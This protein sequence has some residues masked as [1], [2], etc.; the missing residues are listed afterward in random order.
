MSDLSEDE[1]ESTKDSKLAE[2]PTTNKFLKKKKPSAAAQAVES[3]KKA[4]ISDTSAS[5]SKAAPRMG[6]SGASAALSKAAAFTSKYGKPAKKEKV[7]LSDSD[8]DMDLS[9]DEDVS[10]NGLSFGL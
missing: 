4:K 7:M 9:L 1:I 2:E 8:L 10:T 6:Y 5:T 3:P